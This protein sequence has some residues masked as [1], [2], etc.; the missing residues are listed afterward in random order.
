[1]A[2]HAFT[3]PTNESL[4][5]FATLR[6]IIAYLRSPR[7]CPWDRQQTHSTLRENLLQEC[8]EVL[9]AIDKGEPSQLCSELGDLLMQVLLQAQ[10]AQEAGEF[11]LEEVIE[12]ISQKL[13]RRHPHVFGGAPV[14]S[15]EEVAEQW[16]RLKQ[17]EGASILENIPRSLPALAFSQE[18]QSRVARLG[19]DWEELEGVIEKLAEEVRELLSATEEGRGSEFGDLLFTLANIARRVGVDLESALRQANDRFCRRFRY[20]EEVCRSRGVS[21]GSLS[22]AEQNTLWEEAKRKAL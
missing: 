1:M 4:G 7:G 12:G 18:V 3:T 9:E 20:M 11:T 13:I 14:K 5:D 2:E 15:S 19:F 16:E 8:Y 10:I 17:K 6:A 22:F 21:L